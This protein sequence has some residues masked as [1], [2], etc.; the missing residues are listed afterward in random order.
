MYTQSLS[1]VYT[2]S[3]SKVDINRWCVMTHSYVW[4]RA[5]QLC[6]RRANQRHMYTQSLSTPCR[7]Q[8]VVDSLCVYYV[9]TQ[10]LSL[11][12]FSFPWAQ[13]ER[14]RERGE[15]ERERMTVCIM[16]IH[17]VY[18]YTQSLSACRFTS[19]CV[20]IHNTQYTGPIDMSF[21]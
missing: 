2:Q 12:R 8:A 3:L 15:R 6:I 20:S 10:S 9:Y 14:E 17:R 18:V 1:T 16:C 7:W 5:S 13:R 4:H 19:L 21:Y 11:F